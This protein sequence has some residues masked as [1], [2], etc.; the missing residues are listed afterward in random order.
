MKQIKFLMVVALAIFMGTTM[1]SCLDSN[2]GDYPDIQSFVTVDKSSM[3]ETISLLTDDG[4]TLLPTNPSFL[5]ISSGVY[6]DRAFVYAKYA[7]DEQFTEGKTTYNVT[8]TNGYSIPTKEFCTQP[9][10]IVNATDLT[11]LN[12]Y[13]WAANG[14]LNLE[15]G[16]TYDSNK[17]QAFDIYPTEVDGDELTLKVV[18]SYGSSNNSYGTSTTIYSFEMPYEF[19]FNNLLN[20][21]ELGP[22]TPVQDSIYVTVI[23]DGSYDSTLSTNKTRIAYSNFK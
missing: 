4:Y 2:D 8:L 6:P 23:G 15:I 14:Y 11:S 22:L 3:W 21:L 9:D 12:K 7:N 1:T 18:H 16:F 5:E 20:E 10:T 17:Y 19:E 13:F